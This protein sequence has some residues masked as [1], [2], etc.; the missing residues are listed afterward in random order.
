MVLL[1]DTADQLF[2]FPR[3]HEFP[4][5]RPV[6]EKEEAEKSSYNEDEEEKG[7]TDAQLLKQ[8][9]VKVGFGFSLTISC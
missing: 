1:Q 3:G 5:L 2:S 9:A 8:D 6:N 7:L 4:A